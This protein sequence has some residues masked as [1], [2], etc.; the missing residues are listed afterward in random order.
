MTLLEEGLPRLERMLAMCAWAFDDLALPASLG[1]GA[2]TAMALALP[3]EDSALTVDTQTFVAQCA[4]MLKTRL[5]DAS[6]PVRVFRQ[7]RSAFFYAVEHAMS[8][9]A[10]RVSDS[11]L[12]GAVDSLCSRD[13]LMSLDAGGRLLRPAK[14]G[15][16]PGEGAAFLLLER[17]A[18]RRMAGTPTLG[19]IVRASTSLE[20]RHFLQDAPNTGQA[21]SAV[22][23]QLRSRWEQRA[24]IFYTCETGEPFWVAELSMAYLRN[25]P[26]MPE[27]FVRTSAS[28]SFGDL[29]AAAGGVMLGMGVHTLAR[30]RR[31]AGSPPPVLLLCGSADRGHVGA[32]LVQGVQ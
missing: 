14:H 17:A 18:P 6:R 1:T 7:G 22:F 5:P 11:V 8:L 2:R 15:T 25:V 10:A 16:V 29:G 13:V 26:L 30:L 31:P 32:C 3:E 19:R 12:I 4:A 9:I 24:D 20:P 27:P 23:R 28:A 21:L